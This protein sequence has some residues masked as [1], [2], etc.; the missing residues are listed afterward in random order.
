MSSNSMSPYVTYLSALRE[1]SDYAVDLRL[2]E[3]DEAIFLRPFKISQ[4]D[5]FS[6]L[7]QEREVEGELL[8]K[9]QT[10]SGMIVLVGSRGSGKTCLGLKM[11]RMLEAGTAY[12]SFISFIDIRVE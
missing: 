1:V 2:V 7:Y 3:E 12:R 6:Q 5:F 9:L 8:R 10:S 11:K 4:D